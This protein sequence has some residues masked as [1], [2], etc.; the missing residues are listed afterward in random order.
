MR[1]SSGLP[2]TVP[3]R[4]AHSQC[5]QPLAYFQRPLMRKPPSTGFA[6]PAGISDEQISVVSSLPQM[7]FAARSSSSATNQGCTPTTP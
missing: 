5:S 7:S 6:T 1:R 4:N 3:P 2:S